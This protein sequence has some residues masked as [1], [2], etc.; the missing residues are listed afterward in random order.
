MYKWFKKSAKEYDWFGHPIGLTFN[1][2]GDTHNTACGGVSSIVLRIFLG[3][4]VVT[5][6]LILINRGAPSI[7]SQKSVINLLEYGA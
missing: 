2:K 1:N 6:L 5:K 4:F 7:G 3:W